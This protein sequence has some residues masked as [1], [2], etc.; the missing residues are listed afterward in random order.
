MSPHLTRRLLAGLPLLAVI[1]SNGC[2]APDRDGNQAAASPTA[3]TPA[4]VPTPIQP[5]TPAA[6]VTATPA[7]AVPSAAEL[8][9]LVAPVALFPDRLLAQVLAA[10]THPDQIAAEADMLRQNP[11]LNAAALQAALTPQPWDPAVKGLASFPDVLNQMDRSPAWTAALGRAYTSDSTD[12]MN[13]VQVLRQR[14]VNQGHLK[15]TPQQTVVSRTVTTQTVTSGE[16]VPAPQSYVEIEPTQPDVVYVPSYNPALVYGQDY[17]AWPGYYEADGGFDAG[18]SGGLIG[19]GAGIAVGALLS[20]P[21]GWHH[22]GMHWGGPP[23]PGAGMDGWRAPSVYY[24]QRHYNVQNISIHDN[25]QGFAAGGFRRPP[26]GMG[27]GQAAGGPI[28]RS[29]GGYGPP[30]GHWQTPQF[31]QRLNAHTWGQGAAS[32]PELS[33]GPTFQAH[34]GP[35]GGSGWSPQAMPGQHSHP[36]SY[37]H[38]DAAGSRQPPTGLHVSTRAPGQAMPSGSFRGFQQT[39]EVPQQRSTP[40]NREPGFHQEGGFNPAQR[41]FGGGMRPAGQTFR[42]QPSFQ[43]H[44]APV[45]HPAP[46][47]RPAPQGHPHEGGGGH[48]R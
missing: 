47:P 1:G 23:P 27:A 29:G 46:A 44:Q 20:H 41:G 26:V 11:G 35:Q 13:A 36:V 25:R 42:P 40:F 28:G 38:N 15:S 39:G 31:N 4:S 43:Q 3:T 18:W 5:A 22:W 19:F 21:W 10:A 9:R 14:A 7:A 24:D 34:A 16:L 37:I 33:R 17:G 45:F 30:G 2:S 48:H 12:L 32:A 6:A 8:Y